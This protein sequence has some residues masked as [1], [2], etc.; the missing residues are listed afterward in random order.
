VA[1]RT[2]S[3]FAG[4]GCIDYALREW[5]RTVC[6]VEREAYAAAVLV[7][8]MAD[9]ALD[10]APVWD[11]VTTF[12]GL[13]WR[14]KVD[15]VSGGFPC[16]D[17]S[18]A[19]KGAGLAGERSGLW[20]EYARI[21]EEVQ[22]RYVFIENVKALVSRGLETVLGDLAA[23]GFDAEWGVFSAAEVG[24]PHLRERL[25][26]LAHTVGE[27]LPELEQREPARLPHGVRDE[28]EAFAVDD[29]VAL[30]DPESTG[31]QGLGNPGKKK[32]PESRDTGSFP[33]ALADPEREG[34]EGASGRGLPV[35]RRSPSFPPDPDRIRE[36][37][38]PEPAVCRG[39]HGAS[40]RVERLR[41]LGNGVVPQQARRAFL[42]LWSRLK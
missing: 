1:L 24:A 31:L 5:C 16:Q 26:V 9:E 22:P 11:D 14:G 6:Y 33:G 30:A 32:K 39:A 21:V 18:V 19:G 7:A 37:D 35:S 40:D 8:R 20:R 3:L 41:A 15:L 29:D 12:D 38:G 27:P 42:E 17:I 28:G 23:L 36:W 34:L 4:L 10:H 13:P 25:F 2:I